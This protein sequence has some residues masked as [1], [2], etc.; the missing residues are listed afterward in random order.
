MTEKSM[1]SAVEFAVALAH[2]ATTTTHAAEAAAAAQFTSVQFKVRENSPA[3]EFDSRVESKAAVSE[4]VRSCLTQCRP[5]WLFCP[6]FSLASETL[7]RPMVYLDGRPSFC[8]GF[9]FPPH[10]HTSFGRVTAQADTFVF[11]WETSEQKVTQ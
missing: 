9:S 6:N 3:T 7:A 1:T 4:S 10:E 5:I 11:Q 8:T 2:D